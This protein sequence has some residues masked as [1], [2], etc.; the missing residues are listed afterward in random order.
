MTQSKEMVNHPNH[1][2]GEDNTYEVIKVCEAWELDKDDYLFNVVNHVARASKKDQS[3]EQVDKKP[4]N[5]GSKP[6]K[7]LSNC[8]S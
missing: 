6:E 1:Y 5:K 8:D 4:Y 3:T 7:S 2:G